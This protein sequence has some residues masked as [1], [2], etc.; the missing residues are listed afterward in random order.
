MIP[1]T[2]GNL[3]VPNLTTATYTLVKTIIKTKVLTITTAVLVTTRTRVVPKTVTRK[4]M[5][6][7]DKQVRR[8]KKENS[9]HK[10]CN[11][12]LQQEAERRIAVHK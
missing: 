5:K 11:N 6:L 9:G 8:T 7:L 2:M 4:L 3:T 1:N 10:M 12:N